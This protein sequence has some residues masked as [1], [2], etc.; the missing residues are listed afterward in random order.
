MTHWEKT[1]VWSDDTVHSDT[2]VTRAHHVRYYYDGNPRPSAAG[3]MYGLV[4]VTFYGER[5][6]EGRYTLTRDREFVVC[7][8]PNQPRETMRWMVTDREVTVTVY[9]DEDFDDL[10]VCYN[11]N[12][13]AAFYEPDFVWD[14]R[15]PGKPIDEVRVWPR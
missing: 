13:T 3:P 8:D 11:A 10:G 9:S 7:T 6:S 5:T 2:Q 15:A 4:T 14:G 12:R 1:G